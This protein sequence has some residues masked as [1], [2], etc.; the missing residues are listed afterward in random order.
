MTPLTWCAFTGVMLALLLV[1]AEWRGSSLANIILKPLA[2]T[3]F[4]GAAWA[5]GALESSY[6]IAILV[7]LGLSWLG[8]VLLIPKGAKGAFL[9]GLAAFL[10][11]HVAYVVAFV[12]HGVDPMVTALALVP[13]GVAAATVGRSLVG[14]A[15]P[16]LR[17]P[18]V[19]YVA[20][21]S[22]MVAAAAGTF[23]AGGAATLPLGAI[24]F[25]ISDLGVARERFVKQSLWNR[26]VTLPLYYGAQLLFAT[27]V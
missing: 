2:S 15:P 21:I 11:G 12:L 22:A 20:V 9:G 18:V 16:K 8:D 14:A 7:A 25:Y 23:G 17:T 26:M 24:L 19:G 4:L 5:G 3:G 27:S 6:G 13:A 1:F 10:A